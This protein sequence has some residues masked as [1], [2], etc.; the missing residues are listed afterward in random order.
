MNW[1]DYIDEQVGDKPTFSNNEV[2]DLIRSALE[3]ECDNWCN[4]TR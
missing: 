4:R 2:R 3:F 1:S